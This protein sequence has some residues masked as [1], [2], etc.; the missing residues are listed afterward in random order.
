MDEELC[1]LNWTDLVNPEKL[2][3]ITVGFMVEKDP[4]LLKM[5]VVRSKN[6]CVTYEIMGT[7]KLKYDLCVETLNRESKTSEARKKLKKLWCTQVE[8]EFYNNFRLEQI[9]LKIEKQIAQ[10]TEEFRQM[11]LRNFY[12]P[13]FHLN[14][15]ESFSAFWTTFFQYWHN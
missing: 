14:N 2:P 7:L 9:L 12:Q 11:E 15:R 8:F 10:N 3:G 4:E 6:I 1:V 5:C 13:P